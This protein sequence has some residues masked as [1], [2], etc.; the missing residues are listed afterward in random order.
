MQSQLKITQKQLSKFS[1]LVQF[2]LI[3]LPHFKYPVHDSDA[4]VQRHPYEMA[5]WKY[6]ANLQETPMPKPTW[7]W[8][9]GIFKFRNEC[10][11]QLRVEKVDEKMFPSFLWSLNCLRKFIFCNF[12]LTSDINIY[13]SE[14]S[15]YALS[16]NGIVYYTDLL[17]RRY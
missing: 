8:I 12:V 14:R 3:C 10:C 4:A 16:E 11:K 15:C 17:F 2:S 7:K 13:A 9:L 6:V 5:L 1:P